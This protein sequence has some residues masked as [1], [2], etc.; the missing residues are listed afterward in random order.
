MG[1]ALSSFSN[2]NSSDDIREKIDDIALNYIL[3]QNSL[4]LLRLSD[5]EYYDNII[6]LT[7]NLLKS[8]L[9]N[10]ELGIINDRV[11]F[12]N[13]INGN[14]KLFIKSA[15]DLKNITIREDDKTKEKV[16]HFISKFYVKLMMIFAAIISTI[17]PK[18]IHENEGTQK[19]FSLRD[20]NDYKYMKSDTK[21][22]KLYQLMNPMGLIRRR[23]AILK[24]KLSSSNTNATHV[25]MNP[26]ELLCKM[27]LN[28]DGSKRT[29]MNEI[30]I[31]ELDNL[32]YDIYDEETK[33]WSNKS[34]SMMDAY[35]RDLDRFYKIFTGNEMRPDYV[36]SFKDIELLQFH[37]LVRCKNQD[38]FKD[39]MVEK[40][41]E[42]YLK[43]MEKIEN[44]SQTVEKCKR[45]LLD[46]LSSMFLMKESE[47][48]EKKM[49]I[50]PDLNLD[51]LSDIQNSVR[52]T[53]IEL[54]TNS[55]FY[56]IQALLVYEK[57]Y[58]DKFGELTQEVIEQYKNDNSMMNQVGNVLKNSSMYR[59][60]ENTSE[61]INMQPTHNN[62]NNGNN[63]ME[64]KQ[65]VI[66]NNQNVSPMVNIPPL[67]PPMNLP[68]SN[69]VVENMTQNTAPN[70]QNNN[71]IANN[72][73]FQNND[74]QYKPPSNLPS[75]NVNSIDSSL[76]R[77]NNAAS[78]IPEQ[79]ETNES[80]VPMNQGNSLKMKFNANKFKM[81]TSPHVNG[82]GNGNDNETKNRD[83]N[84]KSPGLFGS[85]VNMFSRKSPP[86]DQEPLQMNNN[87]ER[88]IDEVSINANKTPTQDPIG[89]GNQID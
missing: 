42:H 43:Y 81:N 52:R 48:G 12:G 9:N 59:D 31:Q 23:L 6:I 78:D 85:I 53:I 44:I 88:N 46:H 77:P 10:V 39:V 73:I 21:N 60:A 40:T 62:S 28:D 74:L 64:M 20:F 66:V 25:T 65:P 4:D 41:D 75:E 69:N 35:E 83:E 19:V 47:D 18:Y 37:K 45:K 63:T 82:N 79:K 24:N 16:L 13:N 49:V 76:L 32:Y 89:E 54:Y 70:V 17:D 36:K 7:A 2:N 33:K 34:E 84:K 80:S 8:N 55:E 87:K 3:T 71:P 29:L 57:I 14:N 11:S 38:F 72:N 67:E 26:G 51:E 56:F 58:S 5:K 1:N 86:S 68:L 27:N 61:V 30:G 50:N 22:I 15:D